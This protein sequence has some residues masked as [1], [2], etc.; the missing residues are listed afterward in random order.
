MRFQPSGI[1]NKRYRRRLVESTRLLG[2]KGVH[3][4]ASARPWLTS[5]RFSARCRRLPPP[6]SRGRHPLGLLHAPPCLGYLFIPSSAMLRNQLDHLNCNPGWVS[7]PP[8]KLELLD[9]GKWNRQMRTVLTVIM[10]Q[11]TKSTLRRAGNWCI[12]LG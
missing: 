5:P 1:Q 12:I 10:C 9:F 3:L 6:Q 7:L 4:H 11:L 2:E 8:K